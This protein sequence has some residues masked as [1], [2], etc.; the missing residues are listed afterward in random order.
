MVLFI[1]QSV[2]IC[3]FI[4]IE[5]KIINNHTSRRYL[6]FHIHL[7]PMTILF[8]LCLCYSSSHHAH[9]QLQAF[10]H[11]DQ[12]PG[13]NAF[14]SPFHT[15]K[16]NLS[17][18]D[19]LPTAFSLRSSTTPPIHMVCHILVSSCT[20]KRSAIITLCFALSVGCS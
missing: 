13:R 11:A 8:M 20:Y 17:H 16:S 4:I 3:S 14:P 15:C 6:P 18:E 5:N 12:I 19:K 7:S 1:L 2:K 10:A 9:S